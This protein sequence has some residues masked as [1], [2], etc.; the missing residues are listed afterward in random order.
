MAKLLDSGDRRD[1]GTGAVRDM[2]VGKG[3]CDL[4]P[5]KEVGI[6][7]KDEILI[8]INEFVRN[9]NVQCVYDAIEIFI[10][11]SEYSCKEEAM[12]EL[13]KHYEDGAIKYKERNWEAGIPL[14][15]FIDSGI[16]HYFKYCRGD[17]DEPHD[18]AFIWNMFG[19]IWTLENHP[20]LSNLPFAEKK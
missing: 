2:A 12:L 3:R 11:K 15:C 17:K 18:R 5:L 6:F 13:A 7:M 20:E 14:N 16:R 10:A 19:A 9:G 8:K 4:L 1:F